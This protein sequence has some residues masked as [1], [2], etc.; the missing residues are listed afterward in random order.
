MV[1]DGHGTDTIRP[2]LKSV[3]R[4][5][6][7]ICAVLLLLVAPARAQEPAP[8]QGPTSGYTVFLRGAPLGREDIG[9]ASDASGMTVTSRS[10]LG[11]PLNVTLRRVEIKYGPDWTPTSFTSEGTLNDADL[12]VRTTFTG[13]TAA[14]DGR[15]GKNAIAIS[16]QIPPRT[17]VLP[18]PLYGGFAGYAALGRR[19]VGT[20]PGTEIPAY[21][22]PLGQVGV[23][24]VS[25]RA[26]RMQVG[27]SVFN[28]RRYELLFANPGGNQQLSVTTTED[29]SLVR[30]ND[31]VAALDVV[32]EDV[33]A[34]T[35]RTEVHA[36]PGDESVTI[37]AVGFNL[38]AT[39][40]RPKAVAGAAPAVVLVSSSA[41]GDRDGFGFG[42][43]FLG[44]LAGSLADAGFLVVRYDRRGFG[45][46]GG[47][48]ES[49]TLGDYADDVRTVVRWLGERR[50]I[51]RNRIALVGHGDGGWVALLA[52]SRERRRIAAV[53]TVGA[54]GS[55][56]GDLLLEQQQAALDRLNLM[57]AEREQRIALQKQIHSAIATGKGWENVP[58]AMRADADTAWLQSLLAFDPARTVA[59]VRQPLLIVHGELDRHVPVVHADRL[60]TLA[61]G[62]DGPPSTEVVIVRGIDHLLLPGEGNDSASGVPLRD[63]IIS[64]DVTFA[65]TG[66]L[67]RTM[68]GAR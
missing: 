36:N 47:R 21:I 52:G 7:S 51:D 6:H 13:G 63:R 43:P 25:A 33:A 64:A 66:W 45:Q 49:A 46:S 60:A 41:S 29:G 40:T 2:G 22:L 30:L 39:V 19:L 28:V 65:L 50:D 58:K 11:L 54:P 48:S 59:D 68:K 26:E 17:L 20:E 37:P 57:P 53:A 38:A 67:T 24:V 44:Q 8:Q 14:T 62:K 32:R 34:S 55:A 10:R 23:R 42:V 56:G 31:P 3:M 4:R 16:H 35:S 18:S 12:T 27:T 5:L 9:V 61:R 1:L 15:Q